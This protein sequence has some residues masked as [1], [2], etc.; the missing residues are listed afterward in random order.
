MDERATRH[1][2]CRVRLAVTPAQESRLDQ[3]AHAARALWNLLHELFTVSGARRPP[4]AYLDGEIRWARANVDWL[5]VLPAQA[6]QAVL[7]AYHRAWV[8]CWEGRAEAPVYKSRSCV[9]PA[10]DIP[11][12]RDLRVTR[13]HRRWGMVNIPK[14]GRLRFRWTKDLP[15]VTKSSPSGRIT[16]ARLIKDALGW[17]IVFRTETMQQA[18]MP[19]DWGR[20]HVG[21]DR[22]ITVPLA[23]SDGSAYGH[24]PWL[25]D[26]EDDRMLRAQRQAA[27]RKQY[28]GPQGRASK[29]LRGAYDQIKNLRAR[30]KRRVLDWQHK[31][32]TAIAE[33][34]ALVSVEQL[35]I[36]NMVKSAKGTVELPG[37]KVAQKAGLN[38]GIA[39]E[40]WGRTVE[41]LAYKLDD[42]G[43]VLI[44]VPAPG[45]SL[46]CS[47]CG[48]VTPG[49]RES[50]ARFV[51]RSPECGW[52]GNADFNASRNIDQAGLVLASV[53][54][55]AV[56]RQT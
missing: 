19:R 29:R 18:S 47:E 41:L 8:N 37:V 30:A 38:R 17:H 50:Q 45:T 20:S 33:E 1:R 48:V 56:V 52:S 15:G 10:V 24:G 9:V 32:T 23:L 36:V 46:R 7:K 44:R 53:A 12:G 16:G 43:G 4:L 39:G 6:A 3:Q 5:A 26:A 22:G 55:R 34:Y 51:C 21:I 25:T 49:S 42:R 2:G 11:Q 27:H 40:A 54:G 13:V 28:G 35:S 14:L 31:A